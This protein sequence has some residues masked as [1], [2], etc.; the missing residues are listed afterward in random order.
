VRW[1]IRPFPLA[2]KQA[3]VVAT[4]VAPPV[5]IHSRASSNCAEITVDHATSRSS[6]WFGDLRKMT[7]VIDRLTMPGTSPGVNSRSSIGTDF[8]TARDGKTGHRLS[9]DDAPDAQHTVDVS[10]P[11]AL[12]DRLFARKINR[13]P[14]WASLEVV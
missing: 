9:I 12:V 6:I 1:A 7:T 2:Q 3:G 8:A 5:K 4:T 11:A 14:R 13:L 10:T